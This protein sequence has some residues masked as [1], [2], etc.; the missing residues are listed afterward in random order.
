VASDPENAGS[1]WFLVPTL[2]S[3]VGKR[4]DEAPTKYGYLAPDE[5]AV[6][7]AAFRASVM[8][9][10]VATEPRAVLILR[11]WEHAKALRRPNAEEL[12]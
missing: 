3:C 11:N 8:S 4:L 5:R 12:D 10:G 6:R 2:S 7:A 9:R 1:V